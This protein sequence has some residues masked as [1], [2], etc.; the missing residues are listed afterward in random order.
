MAVLGLI[1]TSYSEFVNL[2]VMAHCL[3]AS[4]AQ[5]QSIV[6]MV[7]VKFT[8]DLISWSIFRKLVI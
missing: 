1:G 6:T 5:M 3:L 8:C 4:Q 7:L 2:E